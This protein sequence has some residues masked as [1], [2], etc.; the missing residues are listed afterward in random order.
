MKKLAFA[1]ALLAAGA[2]ACNTP[3]YDPMFDP[4]NYSP[5]KDDSGESAILAGFKAWNC[6]TCTMAFGGLD[7]VIQTDTFSKT[8]TKAASWICKASGAVKNGSEICP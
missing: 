8:F 1:L 3:D 6:A 7:R 4:E 5:E 2:T